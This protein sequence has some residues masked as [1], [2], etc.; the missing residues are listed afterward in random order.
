M[1]LSGSRLR[2]DME[3]VEDMEVVLVLGKRR[4]LRESSFRLE[5]RLLAPAE[6]ATRNAPGVIGHAG[7]FRG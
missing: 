1:S 5:R 6:R 4:V 7:I 2:E 3:D